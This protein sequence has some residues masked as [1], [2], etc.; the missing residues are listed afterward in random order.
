MGSRD[1]CKDLAF[2]PEKPGIMGGGLLTRC[3]CS[4]CHFGGS[5]GNGL[6]EAMV[7]AWREDRNFFRT[8]R[9]EGGLDQVGGSGR[10][11]A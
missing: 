5:I 6:L 9:G 2:P 3:L 4:Q 11:E 8:S 10:G 7:E 1:H